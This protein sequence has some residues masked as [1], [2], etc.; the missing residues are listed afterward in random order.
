MASRS[1]KL[2]DLTFYTIPS[3]PTLY[4]GEVPYAFK[5]VKLN[6]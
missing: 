3:V 4:G 5:F 1:A 2:V 6:P